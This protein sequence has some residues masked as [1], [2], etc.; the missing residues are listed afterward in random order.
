MELCSKTGMASQIQQKT[1]WKLAVI[2][3][4]TVTRIRLSHGIVFKFQSNPLHG[5]KLN[6]AARKTQASKRAGCG[7]EDQ[8]GS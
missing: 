4:S 5:D 8:C 7:R 6:S 3:K 2:T 1:P